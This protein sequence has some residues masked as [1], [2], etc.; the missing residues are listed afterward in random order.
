M[1]PEAIAG[2]VMVTRSRDDGCGSLSLSGMGSSPEGSPTV[3]VLCAAT[4]VTT[5]THTSYQGYWGGKFMIK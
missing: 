4:A 3:G 5:V 1:E 2:T